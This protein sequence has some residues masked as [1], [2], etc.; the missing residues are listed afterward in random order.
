MG[1][2]WTGLTEL[3]AALGAVPER[4][5]EASLEGLREGAELAVQE[6]QRL[7]DQKSHSRHTRTP[8]RPGEP[9]ARVSG[10]LRDSVHHSQPTP[11]GPGMFLV[12]VESDQ[13]YSAIQEKGGTAGRGGRSHLPARPYMKPAVEH[14]AALVVEMLAKAWFKALGR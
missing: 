13:D 12:S 3:E 1:I 6:T 8:S 10:A 5:G 14:V 7:L 4:L 9:P 2:E 11:V